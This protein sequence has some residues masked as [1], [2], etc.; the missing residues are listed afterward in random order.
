MGLQDAIDK[1]LIVI[2]DARDLPG[3]QRAPALER[4]LA[5]TDSDTLSIPRKFLPA[6]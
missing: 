3:G 4:L 2:P 6:I 1:R 5:V